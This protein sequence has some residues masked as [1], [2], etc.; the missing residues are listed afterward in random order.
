[1]IERNGRK[2]GMEAWK[3]IRSAMAVALAMF[4]M[5]GAVRTAG[6]VARPVPVGDAEAVVR[7][8]SFDE[9]YLTLWRMLPKL[10]NGARVPSR[11]ALLKSLHA[12]L[13]EEGFDLGTFRRDLPAYWFG[14]LNACLEALE[15][16][17]VDGDEVLRDMEMALAIPMTPPNGRAPRIPGGAEFESAG[18][19]FWVVRNGWNEFC[20][21]YSDGYAIL[22]MQRAAV[23]RAADRLRTMPVRQPE[24]ACLAEVRID[25]LKG[26]DEYLVDNIGGIRGLG[27]RPMDEAGDV[28]IRGV[29]LRLGL[30]EKKG[31]F[32]TA[33]LQ[34]EGVDEML[35]L[36]KE[37]LVVPEGAL[38][39]E[40][41]SFS[42][43]MAETFAA[44]I[45]PGLQDELADEDD[46]FCDLAFQS[47]LVSFVSKLQYVRV[48]LSRRPGGFL[49]LEEHIQDGERD[50]WN[51]TLRRLLAS[52][53]V[54]SSVLLTAILGAGSDMD[55]CLP[56]SYL[57]DMCDGDAEMLRLADRLLGEQVHLSIRE[58]NGVIDMVAEG[59]AAA[60]TTGG[61]TSVERNDVTASWAMGHRLQEFFP[62]ASVSE[63]LA[64]WPSRIVAEIL[65]Q[66]PILDF[67]APMNAKA[68][69]HG[70]VFAVVGSRPNEWLAS[71]W[72][73]QDELQAMAKLGI[74]FCGEDLF[75]NEWNRV[76][77]EL[78]K[79]RAIQSLGRHPYSDKDE[80]WMLQEALGQY[81]IYED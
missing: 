76:V 29:I 46:A 8:A 18:T 5:G 67:A 17:G 42:Q 14:S 71:V 23:R 44:M 61:K 28:H 53:H 31:L 72:V 80:E 75:V 45:L 68:A 77:E 57:A 11:E 25:G 64:V 2:D 63:V 19:N 81:S 40:A 20:L 41:L 62:G 24:E 34:I 6:A 43:K 16:D 10:V 13:S 37:M 1:M 66:I 30:A 50:F 4:C 9:V 33:Q 32:V 58:T 59:K 65:T 52:V 74:K 26:W 56:W 47:K 22:G 60:V 12:S 79:G 48:A 78:E 27:A 54:D 7:V 36:P 35:A 38:A 69:A 21:L 15:S 39:V 49:R 3:W 55:I 70:G 51:V 73:E